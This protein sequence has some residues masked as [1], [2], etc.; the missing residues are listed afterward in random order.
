[1]TPRQ[2]SSIAWIGALL[3]LAL[4]GYGLFVDDIPQWRVQLLVGLWLLSLLPRAAISQ[5]A[6]VAARGMGRL[7][8]VF[9]LGFTAVALQLAREQIS[10]ASTIHERAAA[11]LQPAAAQQPDSALT[12]RPADRT[13]LGDGRVWPVATAAITRGTILDRNGVVLA[14]TQSGRRVYPNPDLGQIVGFQSRLYPASGR[15]R[16]C[17]PDAR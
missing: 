4:L 13:A 3:G 15:W 9:G 11:L 5:R 2:R 14:M 1:M 7:A 12:L 16:G 10:Q 8:L 6:P 17:A